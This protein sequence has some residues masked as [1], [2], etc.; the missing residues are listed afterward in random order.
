MSISFYSCTVHQTWTNAKIIFT[1]CK[2]IF[3]NDLIWRFHKSTLRSVGFIVCAQCN[4]TMTLTELYQQHHHR[5]HSTLVHYSD[6]KAERHYSTLWRYHASTAWYRN[7]T[8]QHS[9]LCTTL[10]FESCFRVL[11][12]NFGIKKVFTWVD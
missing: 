3:S 9:L 10:C 6:L 2:L 8:L 4:V 7:K 5:A 12:L 11:N 1:C